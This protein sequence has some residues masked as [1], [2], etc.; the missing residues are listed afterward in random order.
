VAALDLPD[1]PAVEPARVLSF[2]QDRGTRGTGPLALLERALAEANV[3][4]GAIECIAV[5]LGPGSYTGIRGAIAIAQGWQLALDV[6]LLGVSTVEALAWQAQQ[7]RLTGSVHIA[8]DA[9]R[10]EFYVA[11]YRIAAGVRERLEPLRL[12]TAPE[13]REI[14]GR[15]GQVAGPGL[16]RW[17]PN[18][19]DL[20]PMASAVGLL[21]AGRNDFLAGEKLEP[22]Y[23]REIAFVKAAPPQLG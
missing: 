7:S 23:L 1:P 13:L 16:A 17:F 20:E 8:I 3:D 22:I 11:C 4:R 2:A 5:G 15:G 18:A 6:K 10:H 12:A 9:Q 19:I 21:A 14:I